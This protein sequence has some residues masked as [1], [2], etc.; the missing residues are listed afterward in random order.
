MKTKILIALFVM[1]A[2]GAGIWYWS[3]GDTSDLVSSLFRRTSPT[4]SPRKTPTPVPIPKPPSGE[5]AVYKGF[6]MPC[7]FLGGD[8]QTMMSAT[9]LKAANANIAFIAPTVKIN[10]RGAVQ[11][12]TPMDNIERRLAAKA[13]EYYGAG[14]RLG[15]AIELYY[16]KEFTGQGSGEPEPLPKD[17]AQQPGFL[18]KYDPLVAQ[19]AKLA[20]KYGV[21]IFSPMSEP[22][23]KLGEATASQ[24]AQKILPTV[25]KQYKGKVLW[26]AAGG[27]L[28]KYDTNFAGYDIIGFDP[29]PGGGPFEQSMTRYRSDVTNL[30]TIAKNRAARDG[31]GYIMITEFGTWGGALQFTEEQKVL[32]H[33][34][35]FELAQGKV[36]GFI[37]LDPPSDLDRGLWGTSTYEEI[38]SWFEKL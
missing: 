10:S 22:D 16:E 7:G 38:R 9:R 15:I 1:I 18:D 4:V 32:A 35:V 25:K 27:A 37:A 29:S 8:C 24:W 17:I 13:K 12:D 5:P 28:D 34:A 36:K 33:R 14:I 30:L 3:S 26:K 23:L 31:V 2:A 19:I 11:L 21:E 20:Q 6:W